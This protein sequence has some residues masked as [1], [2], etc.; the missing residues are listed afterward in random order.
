[1]NRGLDAVVGGWS[2]ATLITQQSGQPMAITDSLARLANGTQRPN[3]VCP[4][5]KSGVSWKS[6]AISQNAVNEGVSNTA[7]LSFFNMNCFGEPGDQ[8]PGNAPRYISTLRT[9]GIHDFDMNL[10]KSFVPK[11]G[12]KIDVRAEI[13]NLF[14]HP[15]FGV[16]DTG[17][18]DAGFGTVTADA[19]GYL[20]RFFQFGLRFEF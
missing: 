5:L 19:S 14:N 10:Y 9:N 4:Q 7:P 6:A 20:P 3:L 16:P 15:R 8:N 11:E 1:M 13:F 18:N 12:M 17:F 2:I